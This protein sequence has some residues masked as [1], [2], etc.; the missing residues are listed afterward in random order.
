MRGCR[1]AESVQADDDQW[2]A[3]ADGA[4]R[5]LEQA[6][7]HLAK[8]FGKKGAGIEEAA[9]GSSVLQQ[10]HIDYLV[11]NDVKVSRSCNASTSAVY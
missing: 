1:R 4:I 8:N 5:A 2:A 7:E 9:G 6:E 3:R 10:A 11:F